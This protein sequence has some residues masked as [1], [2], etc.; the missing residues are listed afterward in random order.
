MTPRIDTL[1]GA[2]IVG[3]YYLVPCVLGGWYGQQRE[4]P[5][6]GPVHDDRAHFN[7]P[8]AH[9]HLDTRFVRARD[10]S[11]RWL[12]N[13]PVLLGDIRDPAPSYRRRLCRRPE[14]GFAAC[15]DEIRSLK[16]WHHFTEAYADARL[17]RDAAGNWVCPHRGFS[18]ASCPVGP[19]GTIVC[20]L[21]GLRWHADSGRA[22][23][24]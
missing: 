12:A 19:D 16:S 17:R 1:V 6:I 2:P 13:S 18:L 24:P 15:I 9:Y 23:A 10:A 7:F 11:L 3:R 5:V 21:H 8:Y 20:P 4:W 22:A 14:A